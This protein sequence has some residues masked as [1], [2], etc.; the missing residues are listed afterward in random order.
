MLANN[1]TGVCQ[2]LAEA[3]SSVR[4]FK[5][6]IHTDAVQAVG[7]IP[8]NFEELGETYITNTA[9]ANFLLS[10]VIFYKLANFPFFVII[11]QIRFS[12]RPY[13]EFVCF[14]KQFRGFSYV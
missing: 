6:F 12:K 3:T 5:T 7:K 1:E 9:A 8:V 13:R 10:E 11:E 14:R 4:D 2:P